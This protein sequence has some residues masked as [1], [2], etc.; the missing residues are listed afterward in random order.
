MR[1]LLVDDEAPIREALARLFAT[2]GWDLRSAAT[3]AEAERHLA[4]GWQAQ[5]LLVDLRLGE[6][7]DGLA[8]LERLRAR[9]CHAPAW[10]LTGDTAPERIQQAHAA[11]LPI[12][13]KPV[14]GL[15]LAEE[16]AAAVAKAPAG[17]E[18]SSTT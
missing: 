3:A 7:G 17:G 10:L 12:R 4:D 11:G 6:S 2:L 9:G 15:A 14:D 13:F 1:V 8:L 5:A 16:M 18:R